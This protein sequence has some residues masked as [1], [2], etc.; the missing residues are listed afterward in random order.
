MGGVKC[1]PLFELFGI[2]LNRI[3]SIVETILLKLSS[4][5]ICDQV[6]A[7]LKLSDLNELM[8]KAGPMPC[9]NPACVD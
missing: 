3:L 9:T 1:Q 4:G 8:A 6:F 7:S 2:S 5:K